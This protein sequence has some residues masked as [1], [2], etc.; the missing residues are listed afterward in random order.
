M[1]PYAIA[2]M[3]AEVRRFIDWYAEF[4][5]HQGL[6]GCTPLEVYEN[7]IPACR[8]PRFEPRARYPAPNS[9]QPI[10]PL[11]AG[12]GAKLE[13]V[14]SYFEGAWH[15]PIVELKAAA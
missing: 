11:R 8:G 5:P 3:R 1:V 7:R 12:R 2:A 13:L 9:Q 6:G 15:L 14:I 10:A 4:R